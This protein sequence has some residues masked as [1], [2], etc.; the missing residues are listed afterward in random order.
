[1]HS[2]R[3]SKDSQATSGGL[4][5]SFS[6]SDTIDGRACDRWVWNPGGALPGDYSICFERSD[7][8][9]FPVLYVSA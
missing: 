8:A 9:D 1:M 4:E 3:G 5:R 2:R 7:T 6:R